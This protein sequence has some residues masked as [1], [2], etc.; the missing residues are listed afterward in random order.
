MYNNLFFK[1]LNNEKCNSQHS[2]H[3]SHLLN[4]KRPDNWMEK[5]ESN[6]LVWKFIKCLWWS[7]FKPITQ[8][9]LRWWDLNQSHKTPMRLISH[10]LEVFESKVTTFTSAQFRNSVS[11][12]YFQS[13]SK[14]FTSWIFSWTFCVSSWQKPSFWLLFCA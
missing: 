5:V 12:S 14:S 4:F 11:P 2:K 7:S 8:M 3:N 6:L 10:P 13:N 9:R 1:E